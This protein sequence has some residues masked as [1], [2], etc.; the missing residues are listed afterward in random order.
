MIYRANFNPR[1]HEECD[2]QHSRISYRPKLFQSTHSR[3]VRH[4]LRRVLV[5]RCVIS[6]HA[7]TRSATAVAWFFDLVKIYFNPRTHEECDALPFLLFNLAI[8]DFN[9]RTHEECDCY[10]A[11]GRQWSGKF[12]STHSRG[13]RL[14][15]FVQLIPSVPISIHAL[16]RSATTRL[17]MLSMITLYFNPRTHEECD[18]RQWL[19][20]SLFRYFNPRT[21]EECDC[22]WIKG[23]RSWW[24][25]NPRTHEECDLFAS[26]AIGSLFPFQSTHSRGVRPL[27]TSPLTTKK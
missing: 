24:Y 20:I 16:T 26:T 6:I 17:S 4:A 12:Q 5:Y 2:C 23:S 9:P 19:D 21:H 14:P 1:T 10:V 22:E 3:G 27:R 8:R 11:V 13:V 18:K 25:F 15:A 7:L